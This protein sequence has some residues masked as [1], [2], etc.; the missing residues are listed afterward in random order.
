MN[1]LLGNILIACGLLVAVLSGLCSLV[2]LSSGGLGSNFWDTAPIVLLFGGI[3]FA[4][5]LGL[6]YGGRSLIKLQNA[7]ESNDPGRRHDR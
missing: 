4:V 7:R 1:R 5:G 2:V 3:P 6:F